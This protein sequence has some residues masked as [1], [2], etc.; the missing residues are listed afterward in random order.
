M[1]ATKSS[2]SRDS[3]P[4]HWRVQWWAEQN[5][6]RKCRCFC[7]DWWRGVGVGNEA[8]LRFKQNQPL[9]AAL[10]LLTKRRLCL[11][12]PLQDEALRSPAATVRA[13]SSSVGRSWRVGTLVPSEANSNASQHTVR[14]APPTAL[15]SLQSRN[16]QKN[17]FINTSHNWT[18]M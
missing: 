1:C 11:V 15:V 6:R 17:A 14:H 4:S 13:R 9:C 3:A 5:Q 18:S 8:Q 2:E 16:P 12:R 7:L 10:Q